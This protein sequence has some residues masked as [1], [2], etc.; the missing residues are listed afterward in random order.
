MRIENNVR[1][2]SSERVNEARASASVARS[3]PST[4]PSASA[5][6][7][8]GDFGLG[9]A[10]LDA[11]GRRTAALR[12]ESRTAA[13]DRLGLQ[14]GNAAQELDRVSSL[15]DEL[16]GLVGSAQ[17]ELR[18]GT[19]SV[20]QSQGRIDRIVASITDNVGPATRKVATNP[21]GDFTQGTGDGGIPDGYYLTNVNSDVVDTNFRRLELF[22]A[23]S[24]Q[25]DGVITQSAQ[26]GGFFLSF[27]ASN[28]NLSSATAQF[29]IEVRG[30]KGTRSLAFASG[31]NLA[32]VT[33]AINSYTQ[34]TGV[35]ARVSGTTGI[36]LQSETYG[37]SAFVSVKIANDGGIGSLGTL[38]L[39]NFQ[40]GDADAVSTNRLAAFSNANNP[41]FDFGQN[42]RANI[43][44]VLA[45]GRGT[46]LTV[47]N[48]FF[49]M[50][51]E[52]AYNRTATGGSAAKL[53]SLTMFSINRFPTLAPPTDSG[54]E[55][56]TTEAAALRAEPPARP[57]PAFGLESLTTGGA[58]SL[59]NTD[60][61]TALK[62]IDDAAAQVR[63]VRA[64]LGTTL[65]TL[66]P[67]AAKF[68]A[69]RFTGKANDA[70]PTR[71]AEQTRSAIIA[72][73]AASL[74]LLNPRADAVLN[75][76]GS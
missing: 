48:D 13:I 37:T 61:R 4:K 7:R 23:Q 72:A 49:D 2:A 62:L 45:T 36:R 25:V 8:T 30:A 41:I 5:A 14:A 28:L 56:T 67:T 69:D 17:E 76:L 21:T 59:A 74:G 20:A 38:G 71:G 32:S 65:T 70:N 40:A 66:L 34:F 22:A 75:L 10:A 43:N 11:G 29:N 50:D 53:G 55:G 47:A 42:I 24:L 18:A 16:R 52:L 54:G 39:Y 73:G 35:K 15:L 3:A 57:G 26:V 1:G 27:G 6:A 51:I 19:S 58:L 63:A 60:P 31:T 33:A 68:E 9:R 46:V 12:F 44:G 64:D